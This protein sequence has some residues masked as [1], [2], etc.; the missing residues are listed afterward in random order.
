MKNISIE[1]LDVDLPT[2]LPLA[3][4]ITTIES[5]SLEMCEI[6]SEEK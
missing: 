3:N 1:N 2:T 5:L 6:I 4:I